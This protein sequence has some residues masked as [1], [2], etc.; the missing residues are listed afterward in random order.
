MGKH[1]PVLLTEAVEALVSDTDGLYVDGTYGRGGHSFEILNKLSER[2]S[3]LAIDKDPEAIDDG[4]IRFN[5][6]FRIS[7]CRESFACIPRLLEDKRLDPVSGILLDLGVSSPQLESPDRGFSFQTDGPLDMRMDNTTGESAADWLQSASKDDIASV[8]KEFG[9]ERY[10]RRI[11]AAIVS[12][13]FKSPIDS[14]KRLA[15]II[16]KAHPSWVR[17]QH[18]ATKSFQGIR[19]YINRELQDLDHFLEHVVDMLKIGG[20]LVVISFHSL[21]DRRVKRFI[22]NQERREIFPR[23]LPIPDSEKLIRL[24]KVGSAIKPSKSEIMRNNRAR[25]AVMRVAE[26]VA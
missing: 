17:G 21:E 20:R 8:I 26:R 22:R 9:G 23:N 1:I 24:V 25:S 13:R 16:K 7:F 15:E 11:S 4:R 14:T 3:V 10:A 2:G 5:Q 12:E 19:I 18:P 6:E